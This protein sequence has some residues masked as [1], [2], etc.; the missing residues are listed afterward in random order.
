[1]ALSLVFHGGAREWRTQISSAI[2]EA[3]LFQVDCLHEQCKRVV[4]F[5]P[6]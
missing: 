2:G 3:G 5:L 1:M 6:W 4:L